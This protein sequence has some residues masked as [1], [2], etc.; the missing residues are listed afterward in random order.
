MWQYAIFFW[1]ENVK[2]L[3]LVLVMVFVLFAMEAFANDIR[4][5]LS[6]GGIECSVCVRK[7]DKMLMKTEGIHKVETDLK[8]GK[9]TICADKS[10]I[11]EDAK[12]E[13]LFLKQGFVYNGMVRQGECL[14]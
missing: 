12:L 3:F 11:L 5:D 1:R 10:A 14:L 7:I 8:S 6:V 4:Y 13:A 9:V 2:Q